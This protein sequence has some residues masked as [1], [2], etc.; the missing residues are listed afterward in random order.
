LATSLAR[1][2]SATSF[3]GE[4]RSKTATKRCN[5]KAF[6]GNA[7]RR[8]TRIPL[9]PRLPDSRFTGGPPGSSPFGAPGEINSPEGRAYPVTE[10]AL[11]RSRAS[12]YPE[13]GL[14]VGRPS[15][16]SRGYPSPPLPCG[17]AAT[18][19]R[20]SYRASPQA[21]GRRPC[22]RDGCRALPRMEGAEGLAALC[23]ASPR[24]TRRAHRVRALAA[25]VPN[26]S[27]P[28]S[29]QTV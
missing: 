14:R 8:T 28:Q 12:A 17:V 23:L 1:S 25:G 4:T 27:R 24:R 26:P 18:G 15:R 5:G 16:G 21:S 19:R 7:F 20:R 3:D 13:W 2:R 6:N 10:V 22:L 29:Y 11:S 9:S